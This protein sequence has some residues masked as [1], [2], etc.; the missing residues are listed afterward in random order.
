VPF[1]IQGVVQL[2]GQ[3]FKRRGYALPEGIIGIPVESRA[4]GIHILHANSGAEDPVGT[5]VASLVLHYSDGQQTELAIR[6]GIHLLDW[7]V[8]PSAPLKAAQD[9]NTT[10]AWT[11]RNPPA[12]HHGAR[13]RLFETWFANPE[14]E[15]PI[16]TIDYVSGMAQSAPFMVALTIEH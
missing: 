9:P 3:E 16:Q 6:H 2:Q 7:W 14:S 10:V 12:E 8:W 4:R 15:K 11:G 13:I 1:D 5:T